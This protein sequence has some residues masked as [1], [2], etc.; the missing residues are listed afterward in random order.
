MIKIE[1]GDEEA[2]LYLISSIMKKHKNYFKN[3]ASKITKDVTSA[4]KKL[5]KIKKL[6]EAGE[7]KYKLTEDDIAVLQDNCMVVAKKSF[8]DAEW[9]GLNKRV[10]K[11]RSRYKNKKATDEYKKE[12][13]NVNVAI[14]EELSKLKKKGRNTY[15]E[16]VVFLIGFYKRNRKNNK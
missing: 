9:G 11:R 14:K 13:I 8:T 7:K 16:V 15:D 1:F 2:C 12:S 6:L 4:Y 10:T 5:K 3:D